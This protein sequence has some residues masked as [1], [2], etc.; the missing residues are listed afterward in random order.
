[1]LVLVER[2]K[3]RWKWRLKNK[4]F[5]SQK[6]RTNQFFFHITTTIVEVVQLYTWMMDR[7][8]FGFQGTVGCAPSTYYQRT[9]CC[10]NVIEVWVSRWRGGD[11]LPLAACAVRARS[12][13]EGHHH[14]CCGRESLVVIMVAGE[15][16][17]EML[18]CIPSGP[19]HREMTMQCQ[20]HCR[21]VLL[22]LLLLLLLLPGSPTQPA[23]SLPLLPCCIAFSS[24][25]GR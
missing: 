9:K 13:A 11:R 4:S 8:S 15:D 21:Q 1:M 25:D 12:R 3:E 23:C 17:R 18:H 16:Q 5:T 24:V 20:C 6:E 19:L 2:E 10:T 22:L 7:P 14:H